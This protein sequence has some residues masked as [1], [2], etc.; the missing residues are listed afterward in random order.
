MGILDWTAD[1]Q[2]WTGWAQSDSV[3][4]DAVAGKSVSHHHDHSVQ[5]GGS[6]RGEYGVTVIAEMEWAPGSVDS[7]EGS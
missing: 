2:S 1:C 5:H 7:A 3:H 4:A 6:R